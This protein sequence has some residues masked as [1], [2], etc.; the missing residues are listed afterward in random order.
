MNEPPF[1]AG[2]RAAREGKSITDNPHPEGVE[3]GDN[4]PGAYVNWRAGWKAQKWRERHDAKLQ[5]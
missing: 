4:Y 1:H 5:G 3:Y 2:E